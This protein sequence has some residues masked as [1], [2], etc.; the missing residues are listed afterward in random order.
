[1]SAGGPL[2][3]RPLGDSVIL[4]D[5]PMEAARVLHGRRRFS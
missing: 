2:G 3:E 5:L 1:M 4:E